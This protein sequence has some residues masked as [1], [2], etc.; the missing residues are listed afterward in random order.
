VVRH[1]HVETA[2]RQVGLH[3]Q[4][5]HVA[6]SLREPPRPG[7]VGQVV[8]VLA[9]GGAAPGRVGDD[10]VEI[11]GE[12]PRQ[13][14]GTVAERVEATAV[15]VEGAAALLRARHHDVPPGEGQE[16]RGVLIDG[17][18]QVT[19]D[20]A[21]EQPDP[22]APCPDGRD[23]LRERGGL[24][25][26]A[27][28]VSIAASR[29]NAC[30]TPVARTSLCSPERRTRGKPVARPPPAQDAETARR[31]GHAAVAR[32]VDG[33][34]ARSGRGSLPGA[35]RTVHRRDTPSRRRGSR[36]TGRGGA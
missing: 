21:R 20:A 3:E 16:P 24:G 2:E 12:C 17:R 25:T 4:L 26:S 14:A 15:E 32:P 18:K 35:S 31:R 22:T 9:H 1:R 23:E 36:G 30:S 28:R 19:L 13:R 8:A 10:E 29:G 7:I 34:G 11:V 33:R 27:S 6:R 5:C